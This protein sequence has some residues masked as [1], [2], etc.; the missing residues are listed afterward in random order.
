MIWQ[1]VR[2]DLLRW[3]RDPLGL[4]LWA[5]IPLAIALIMK[6]AFG[7]DDGIAK[8]QLVIVD[9]DDSLVSRFVSGAF[10]QGQL[11]D[12]VETQTADSST[13]VTLANKGKVSAALFIPDGF[14]KDY[15]D[16]R[17]AKLTL[18]RNPS[19]TVLPEIVEGVLEVL[20]DGS[21]YMREIFEEPLALAQRFGNASTDTGGTPDSLV[22]AFSTAIRRPFERASDLLFP[23]VLALETSNQEPTGESFDYFRL[24]FPGI[25]TMSMLFLGQ[26]LAIDLWTEQKAGTFRR[27]AASRFGTFHLV[28][29]KVIA[30]TVILLGIFELFLL[31]GRYLF[32]IDLVRIHEAALYLAL[33]A[34]GMVAIFHWIVV[35]AR[36]Q[37][38]GTILTSLIVMPLVFLGGSFFPIE[39]LPGVLKQIGLITPNGHVLQETKRLLYGQSLTP[40]FWITAIVALGLGIAFTVLADRQARRRFLGS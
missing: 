6:L 22:D 8:A 14:G 3:G 25:L 19:Q 39:A 20:A 4:I 18:L 31:V 35:L 16:G 15:L 32:R 29:G 34:F 17:T 27:A 2:K 36:S 12:L 23:P 13:A 38:A 30:S 9:Q 24:F 28:L 10:R 5:A 1:S 37:N 11:A 7:G 40:S 26:S 33:P 21:F